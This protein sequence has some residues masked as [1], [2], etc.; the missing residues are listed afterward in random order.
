MKPRPGTLWRQG[1]TSRS[2][3]LENAPKTQWRPSARSLCAEPTCPFVLP[4]SSCLLKVASPDCPPAQE[5]LTVGRA[6]CR[7]QLTRSLPQ[8]SIEEPRRGQRRVSAVGLPV[9]HYVEMG[10]AWASQCGSAS[11]RSRAS[12]CKSCAAWAFR[13]S[14][15]KRSCWTLLAPKRHS[16]GVLHQIR[17]EADQAGTPPAYVAVTGQ[18][19]LMAPVQTAA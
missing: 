6:A 7:G 8:A 10:V 3:A 12:I 5:A 18:P 9:A 11:C 17:R 19:N 4:G 14:T 16:S 1:H 15:P 2:R 13:R